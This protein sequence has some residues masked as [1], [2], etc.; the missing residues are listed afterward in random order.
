MEGVTLRLL[1][2]CLLNSKLRHLSVTCVL[3]EGCGCYAM[4]VKLCGS[5]VPAPYLCR[6]KHAITVQQSQILTTPFVWPG[7][8]P[9]Q[10]LLLAHSFFKRLVDNIVSASY[11][12]T[13][14]WDGA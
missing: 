4:L 9:P 1:Q 8:G 13:C 7:L 6:R 12:I 10:H 14:L 5:F 3:P 2:L 11:I